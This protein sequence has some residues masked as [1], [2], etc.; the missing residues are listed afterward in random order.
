M[1]TAILMIII[2]MFSFRNIEAETLN[3]PDKGKTHFQCM[4]EILFA[5]ESESY[6]R[7]A[8]TLRSQKYKDL[9]EKEF[10]ETVIFSKE[11]DEMTN[12][13]EGI[14][15]INET[16]AMKKEYNT[17]ATKAV[18]RSFE[19]YSKAIT[20][21]E[22]N[23]WER[24]VQNNE[25]HG[26]NNRMSYDDIIMSHKIEFNHH[27]EGIKGLIE[28]SIELF[29]LRSDVLP[30]VITEGEIILN[31]KD[32]KV[33]YYNKAVS[34]EEKSKG[35]IEMT[36]GQIVRN[37]IMNNSHKFEKLQDGDKDV[38]K[39]YFKGMAVLLGS[40]NTEIISNYYKNKQFPY[41]RG[42]FSEAVLIAPNWVL[43]S[44]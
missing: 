37:A 32:N 40:R 43:M 31:E 41:M 34:N 26:V 10:L 33:D 38:V 29:L 30:Y 28:T 42:T 11:G 18:K 20:V 22:K 9:I 17:A 44:Y 1:R 23:K 16:M 19:I 5:W 12:R 27:S 36:E 15:H 14:I 4:N 8:G 13:L 2:S 39:L 3:T 6:E 24:A 25:K 7:M 35:N 21:T